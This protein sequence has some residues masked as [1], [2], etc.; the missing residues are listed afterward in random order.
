[1]KLPDLQFRGSSPAQTQSPFVEVAKSNQKLK[2]LNQAQE[3]ASQ[4]AEAHT[5]YEFNKTISGYAD[6]MSAFRREAAKE[7]MVTPA[8]VKTWGI[9]V[10]GVSD[11]DE[12]VSRAKWYPV[13]LAKQMEQA[14]ERWGGKIKSAT[15]RTRFRQIVDGEN[16]KMLERET[17]IAQ[18]ETQVELKAEKRVDFDQAVASGNFDTAS[19]I[20]QD[21]AFSPAERKELSA[22]MRAERFAIDSNDIINT[23]SS[24]EISSY[25]KSLTDK[26]SRAA[27]G[28]PERTAQIF[29]NRAKAELRRREADY[30]SR[31]AKSDVEREKLSRELMGQYKSAVATGRPVSQ[32][33]EAQAQRVVEGTPYE[34][35]FRIIKDT[36]VY[37]V[38]PIDER[39]TKLQELAATD[40][41]SNQ[42]EYESYVAANIEIQKAASKDIYSFG[43]EQG[44]IDYVPLNMGDPESWRTRREQAEELSLQYGLPGQPMS[45][46]EADAIAAA[47]KIMTVDEQMQLIGTFSETPEV[48]G[49][50]VDSGARVFAVAGASKDPDFARTALLGQKQI[51]LGIAIK[52]SQSDYQLMTNDYL[53]GVYGPE[54]QIAVTE[55]AIAVYATL[56]PAGDPDLDGDF[57]SDA[58]QKAL[59]L[60][61]PMGEVNGNK[62][63][64]PR[65]TEPETMQEFVDG[66]SA[67]QVEQSGGVDGLSPEAAALVIQDGQWES[68]DNGVYR[69]RKGGLYLM[70]PAKEG[71]PAKPLEIPYTSDIA[72]NTA[73]KAFAERQRSGALAI[74]SLQGMR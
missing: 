32:E 26:E 7:S 62:V 17:V 4:I 16:N 54:D 20:L 6:E 10:P 37:A 58:W 72:T 33:W 51:D 71:V 49:Q 2:L 63:Q 73:A 11:S 56:A 12:Y 13:A 18:Q 41:L 35:T 59:E 29:T 21:A 66:F 1:M 57:H 25:L 65:G 5:E 14:S 34:D 9:D 50:L 8:Q 68:H 45:N 60:A 40:D 46:G 67:D 31:A 39:M 43:V 61:A 44:V 48:Y 52:P 74:D 47:Q 55:A 64:V 53:S 23:G 69:V 24:A 42:Q 28:V 19:T 22:G 15:S 38:R 27:L 30:V 70:S 36:Q 3:G